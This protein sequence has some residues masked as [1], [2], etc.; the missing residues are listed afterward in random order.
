MRQ[1]SLSTRPEPL[2]HAD[3]ASHA[4]VF[5]EDTRCP[6]GHRTDSGADYLPH[7]L[8]RLRQCRTRR[9]TLNP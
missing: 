9:R 5:D 6:A 4:L 2:L 7:Y 1:V 3:A 8:A